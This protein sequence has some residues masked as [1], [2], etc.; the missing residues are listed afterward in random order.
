MKRIQRERRRRN[1]GEANKQVEGM[2]GIDIGRRRKDR[3][4]NSKTI[5]KKKQ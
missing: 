1:T 2:G 3:R 4:R 5:P